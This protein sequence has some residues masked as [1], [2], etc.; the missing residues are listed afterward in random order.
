MDK[1]LGLVCAISA[2]LHEQKV[3]MASLEVFSMGMK[4]TGTYLARTL[5]YTGADFQLVRVEVDPVFRQ[6]SLCDFGKGT[7]CGGSNVML[8][9]AAGPNGPSSCSC[10]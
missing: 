9:A 7:G 1:G 8:P 10:W 3:G 6:A 5:S 4:A 2:P